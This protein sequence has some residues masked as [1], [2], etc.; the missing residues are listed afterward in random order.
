[1]VAMNSIQQNSPK[2]TK[3]VSDII[4]TSKDASKN[5]VENL[6]IEFMLLKQ[7]LNNAQIFYDNIKDIILNDKDNNSAN[8]GSVD[9]VEN[10][11]EDDD[12][13]HSNEDKTNDDNDL[14]TQNF[15][16]FQAFKD[17]STTAAATTAAIG[18]A[19]E[20]IDSLNMKKMLLSP[21]TTS[22]ID[23]VQGHKVQND[24]GTIKYS[25]ISSQSPS[26]AFSSSFPTDINKTQYV[27]VN[28]NY[29]DTQQPRGRSGN[30]P[31][32]SYAT[33]H[34]SLLSSN[35]KRLITIN[36]GRKI[37]KVKKKLKKL[38]LPLLLAYK[39]KFMALIPLLIG[40]LTLLVGSTGLAGF[41]FALFTTVM[42]LKSDRSVVVKKYEH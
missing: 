29:N 14:Q 12:D 11:N 21:S 6:N 26:A 30:L 17:T 5:T 16:P 13:T 8:S 3:S 36:S 15:S 23:E 31:S 1:M 35:S 42:S 19:I 22:S 25:L 41:F 20:K 39:L 40:G 28:K 24:K 38:L 34:S 37:K 32:N 33:K 2:I 7:T 10:E 27:A 9:D 4:P 18:T